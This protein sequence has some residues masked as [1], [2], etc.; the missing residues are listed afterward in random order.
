MIIE[1]N[2]IASNKWMAMF[3]N[4]HCEINM[5]KSRSNLYEYLSPS[6]VNR[7]INFCN[8]NSISKH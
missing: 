3:P 7:R 6:A 5:V 2:Y 1:R 8:D 4:M